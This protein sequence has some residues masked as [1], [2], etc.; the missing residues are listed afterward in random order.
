LLQAGANDLGFGTIAKSCLENPITDCNDQFF[1][2]LDGKEYVATTFIQRRLARLPASYQALNT[3]LEKFPYG[4]NKIYIN[5]YHDPLHGSGGG[6]C[7]VNVALVNGTDGAVLWPSESQWAYETLLLPLNQAVQTAADAHGWAFVGGITSDFFTH[8]ICADDSWTR[9]VGDSFLMQ[10]DFDGSL[11]PNGQGHNVIANHILQSVW[12]S[13][14]PIGGDVVCPWGRD[15]RSGLCMAPPDPEGNGA[16]F[17]RCDNQLVTCYGN[18]QG[19]DADLCMC[20][21][22]NNAIG[23]CSSCGGG[24]CGQIRECP[25]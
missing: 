4:F 18:C 6:P 15:S 19:A 13:L 1:T 5:D 14:L 10:G 11:H 8:G 7:M 3:E 23:C 25:F 12:P 21:C 24:A 20:L 9:A 16:C 2:D 22:D 17:D